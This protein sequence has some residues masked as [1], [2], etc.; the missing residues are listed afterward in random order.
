MDTDCD[1]ISLRQAAWRIAPCESGINAAKAQLQIRL[2]WVM[3]KHIDPPSDENGRPLDFAR[4]PLAFDDPMPR[5]FIEPPPS[6]PKLA[7]KEPA[8]PDWFGLWSQLWDPATNDSD[9]RDFN[10]QLDGW[11]YGTDNL[12]VS[13]EYVQRAIVDRN[14][15]LSDGELENARA[16]V[17]WSFAEALAWIA[18]ADL[19]E[20]AL[21]GRHMASA[22]QQTRKSPELFAS[23]IAEGV[24][25]LALIVSERH[26]TCGAAP[27]SGVPRW[28]SC[29][30]LSN[31]WAKLASKYTGNGLGRLP[32]EMPR[33]ESDLTNGVFGLTWPDGADAISFAASELIADV[34]PKE[35]GS[36]AEMQMKAERNR[37]GKYKGG[38]ED[39]DAVIIAKAKAMKESKGLHGRVIASKLPKE[40]GFED[41]SSTYVRTLID[42]LFKQ[43]SGALKSG[44]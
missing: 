12:L 40:P 19:V 39:R 33:L 34:Q 14:A 10:W 2:A 16:K 29:K 24:G 1:W 22:G 4:M 27:Q 23:H 32:L 37:A 17:A 42:G 3:S 36:P 41:V 15:C 5:R 43:G 44:G 20:V 35:A 13:W 28:K 38:D 30:C 31:A 11:L 7:E 8:S 25:R 6:H 9:W 18:T 26:C 21:I